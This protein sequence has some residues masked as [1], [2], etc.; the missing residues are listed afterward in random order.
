MPRPKFFK[1]AHLRCN[2][3]A[4][5]CDKR[6]YILSAES[7]LKIVWY[8]RY[9]RAK[10]PIK[11]VLP[12]RS[13]INGCDKKSSDPRQ[14]AQRVHHKVRHQ[15]RHKGPSNNQITMLQPPFVSQNELWNYQWI[16]P[17]TKR[18]QNKNRVGTLVHGWTAWFRRASWTNLAGKERGLASISG[19][20]LSRVIVAVV[21]YIRMVSQVT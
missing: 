3:S 5:Y 7:K 6:S 11:L 10:S 8:T 21:V 9:I 4:S 17:R 14:M 20:I 13:T 16:M 1:T 15:L 12:E 2:G 18:E 19:V